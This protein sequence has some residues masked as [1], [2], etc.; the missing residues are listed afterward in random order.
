MGMSGLSEGSAK[1]EKALIGR[2]PNKNDIVLN[3]GEPI[4]QVE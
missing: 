2:S 4:G 3:Q 1:Y